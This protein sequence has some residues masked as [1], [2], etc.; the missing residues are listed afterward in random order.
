M[1]APGRGQG[2]VGIPDGIIGM[3]AMTQNIESRNH[4]V[5]VLPVVGGGAGR[6]SQFTSAALAACETCDSFQLE[7]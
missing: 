1:R 6:Q 4:M 5:L 7:V 2:A 3:S